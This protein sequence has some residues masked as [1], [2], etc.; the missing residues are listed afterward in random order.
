MFGALRVAARLRLTGREY[1]TG[2]GGGLPRLEACRRGARGAPPGRLFGH[3]LAGFL[4]LPRLR[5]RAAAPYG[6]VAET[7]ADLV[8]GRVQRVAPGRRQGG[9]GGGPTRPREQVHL[10]GG[11]QVVDADS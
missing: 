8:D 3:L 2:F 11:V 4:D 9:T 7:L 6:E 5:Q 1:C 10:V